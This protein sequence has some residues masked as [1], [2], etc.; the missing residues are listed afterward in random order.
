LPLDPPEDQDYWW[1]TVDYEPDP[2]VHTV[3]RYGEH[4]TYRRAV[5]DGY[6]WRERG[7]SVGDTGTL[8]LIQWQRL[9]ICWAGED[10]PVVATNHG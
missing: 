10:H 2:D 3:I 7:S 8:G 1:P 6:V 9:G 5:R 4:P